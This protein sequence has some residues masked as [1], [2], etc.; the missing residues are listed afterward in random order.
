MDYLKIFDVILQLSITGSILVCLILVIRQLIKKTM[1]KAILYYM[2]IILLVKL[3]VPFGLESNFSIYNLFEINSKVSTD[4]NITN[5]VNQKD[6]FLNENS[7]AN[8]NNEISNSN[9]LTNDK[10]ENNNSTIEKSKSN[11]NKPQISIKQIGFFIWIIGLISLLGYTLL[12][13]IKFKISISDKSDNNIL[14]E[15][16][17]GAL[18]EALKKLSIKRHIEI[19]ISDKISTPT[20]Y[21]IIIP[22]IVLPKQVVNNASRDELKYIL[23]H[24]L[25]HYKRKDIIIAWVIIFAKVIY[26]FNPII[27]IALDIM[28]K[29]CETSCDEMVLTY[30][31]KNENLQYGNTILN[32]LQY[33]NKGRYVPGTTSMVTNKKNLKERIT[34]I[35]K[36][37]KLGIKSIVIGVTII[38]IVGVIGLTNKTSGK[39]IKLSIDNTKIE[40]ISMSAMPS[41]PK[42]KFVDRQEDIDKIVNYI[43]SIK[44]K[45]KEQE[46][47][48]GWEF[49]ISIQG[50]EEHS[51][52]VVGEYFEI[53]GIQYK[54]DKKELEKIRELYNNLSYKETDYGL[55]DVNKDKDEA[56]SIGYKEFTDKVE[57]DGYKTI[58]NSGFGSPI[59]LPASFNAISNG[60]EIG[61]LLYQRNIES[62][63][64]GY[65]ITNYLGKGAVIQ[66]FSID[67]ENE[68]IRKD[69]IGIISENKLVAYWLSPDYEGKGNGDMYDIIKALPYEK[70]QGDLSYISVV[71]GLMNKDLKVEEIGEVDKAVESGYSAKIYNIKVNGE[72]VTVYEYIDNKAA[73]SD[74]TIIN[75]GVM[76]N[77]SDL[78]VDLEKVR[79]AKNVYLNG[80]MLCLYDGN[81]EEIEKGLEALLDTPLEKLSRDQLE[82]VDGKTTLRYPGEW[83]SMQVP[84]EILIDN[85]PYKINAKDIVMEKNIVKVKIEIP[86]DVISKF[87]ADEIMVK[88][89]D[90]QIK[91][92]ETNTMIKRENI[93]RSKGVKDKVINKINI[94]KIYP[95]IETNEIDRTIIG[96]ELYKNYIDMHTTNWFFNLNNEI[97][98]ESTI[99]VIE[100]KINSAKLIKEG[101]NIFTVSIS[102]DIHAAN[103]KSEW[104]AGNGVIGEDNWILNKSCFVD[105][106]KIGENKYRMI[107]SY[108]V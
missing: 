79:S 30:L 54:I 103:E 69:I 99:T 3:L 1:S 73:Q 60:I 100:S 93:L 85:K 40:S 21:G 24:E 45:E 75:E 84:T 34:N 78:V 61:N 7:I 49:S 23:L 83:A 81:T 102:Y 104:F 80:K 89:N 98:E 94:D 77:Y 20:F 39:I 44:L 43:N 36:N 96:R 91:D 10:L 92:K 5:N 57:K 63:K 38:L 59:M 35:A 65:D 19:S 105:I 64:N 66:G 58:V 88:W 74:A 71:K 101:K 106:E 12:N 53:D 18:E 51:I 25:C 22:R 76:A 9:I 33:V 15:D 82:I 41:P 47:Y 55:N 4:N 50:E 2:W 48:K 16:I 72:D 42:E 67:D 37:K 52:S 27:I 56:A 86:S 28:R 17:R 90:V 6:I 26:W 8:Q 95:S 32:V 29:D 108:A 70:I 68:G 87:D 31:D 13:Y 97:N 62:I 46:K 107:N 11:L 14:N